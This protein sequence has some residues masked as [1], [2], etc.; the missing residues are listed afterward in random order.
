MLCEGEKR[1][2]NITCE[3]AISGAKTKM[4]P[5]GKYAKSAQLFNSSSIETALQQLDPFTM[6]YNSG[7]PEKKERIVKVQGLWFLNAAGE[8][9]W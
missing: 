7:L 4:L 3:D 6:H 1:T 5:V 9:P 2:S 8:C